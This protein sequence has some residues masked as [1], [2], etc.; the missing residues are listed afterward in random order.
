M[1]AD[2]PSTYAMLNNVRPLTGVTRTVQLNISDLPDRAQGWGMLDALIISNVD[3]GTL[4][5]E[6]KQSLELWLANG[7]KLFVTGGIQWQSTAAG[8]SDLPPD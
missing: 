8:L 4:T 2:N 6:Q 1:V 7:G 3:T 5:S